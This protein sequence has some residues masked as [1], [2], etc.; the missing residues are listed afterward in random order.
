VHRARERAA[1]HEAVCISHQLP[2]WT[3]RRSL[4]GRPLWHHP[5]RRRCALA[6]LTTLVF[7][8]DVLSEIRYSE[9]AGLSDPRVTGA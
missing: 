5:Q 3:L 2:I 6:S 7:A 4:E 1:G 9:P 8:G